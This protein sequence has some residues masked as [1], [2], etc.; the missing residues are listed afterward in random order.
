M[1]DMSMNQSMMESSFIAPTS[2]NSMTDTSMPVQRRKMKLTIESQ[3]IE[4][5][6]VIEDLS[7]EQLDTIEKMKESLKLKLTFEQEK[8]QSMQ[9]NVNAILE[10]KT[11]VSFFLTKIFF[12]KN[13]FFF[14]T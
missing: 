14:N 6:N 7:Q 4:S 8:L 3:F 5:V 2:E 12:F 10:F 9:P 11:K 13:F 1:I